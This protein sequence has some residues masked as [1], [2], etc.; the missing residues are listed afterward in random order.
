MPGFGRGEDGDAL[1]EVSVKPHPFFTRDGNDIVVEVP[2]SL[3]EAVL[4][5]RMTVP[6]IDGPVKVTVPEG[7]NTGTKL[8]LRGKGIG[9]TGKPRGDQFVMLKIVLDDP[10]DRKLA[11]LVRKWGKKDDGESLRRK[12][13]LT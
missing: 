9:G 2:V 3:S 1:V 12:A 11:S 10:G 13:G 5:T 4:G 6:T 8:R 7:S